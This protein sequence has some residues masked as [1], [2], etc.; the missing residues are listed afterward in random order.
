MQTS[1]NKNPQWVEKSS[2]N[3]KNRKSK[4]QR[5]T[6]NAPNTTSNKYV[7]KQEN[8]RD[9]SKI[10]KPDT[11]LDISSCKDTKTD[12]DFKYDPFPILRR[13]MSNRVR[14][15][16]PRNRTSSLEAWEYVYFSHIIDLRNIFLEGLEKL[17]MTGDYL[18][19]EIFFDKFARFIKKNSSGEINRYI[20][21]LNEYEEN[22]YFK[23]VESK[24]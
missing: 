17:E 15:Q 12:E 6:T 3:R 24:K 5:N 10:I 2:K 14:N 19:S 7:E 9:Y 20:K 4:F 13:R 1:S 16:I 21:E 22:M 23:Y 8:T 11:I 18:R